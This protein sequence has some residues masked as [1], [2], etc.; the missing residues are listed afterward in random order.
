[1]TELVW[2]YVRY[3]ALFGLRYLAVAG[4]IYGLLYVWRRRQ[5][6]PYRIQPELPA[7]DDVRYEL[8]W[9][10]ATM[11]CSGLTTLV[12]YALVRGGW[13]RLYFDA[14]RY[15][16]GYFALSVVIGIVGYDAWYYWEHRLLHRPWWFR[17]VHGVH[18]RLTNPTP[19]ATFAHHPMETFMG[20]AYFMLLAMVVPMHPVAVALVS[21]NVFVWSGIV[22]HLGYELYPTAV[23]RSR[24]LRWLNT[25]TFHNLH[26]TKVTTNYG[27][28]F[29][30]WDGLMG[31]A[32]PTYRATFDAV[33][34]RLAA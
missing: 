16:W 22:L 21:L 8:R 10:T 20:A 27:A 3:C 29:T 1:M 24:V 25:A 9:S 23:A 32:H 33:K 19:F 34:T 14:A 13:T 2:L 11:A 26:H 17:H 28:F 31:T 4:P 30:Y 6:A 18:H 15:G 7:P 5:W 12:F